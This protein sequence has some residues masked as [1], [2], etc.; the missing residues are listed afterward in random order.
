MRE[1]AVAKEVN[2][3]EVPGGKDPVPVVTPVIPVVTPEV[4]TQ[5]DPE[6]IAVRAAP[7]VAIVEAVAAMP[8]LEVQAVPVVVT[9]VAAP[10][11]VEEGATAPVEAVPAVNLL[12]S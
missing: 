9:L 3:P 12:M 10:G 7:A 6:E 2:P 1:A 11:V 8:G 5:V 4:E